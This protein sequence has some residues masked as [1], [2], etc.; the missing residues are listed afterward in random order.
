MCEKQSPGGDVRFFP[1]EFGALAC[2]PRLTRRCRSLKGITKPMS[3]ALRICIH[4][5]HTYKTDAPAA[6]A[7]AYGVRLPAPKR[8]D[9]GCANF[10]LCFVLAPPAP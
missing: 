9:S 6:D 3:S 1:E 8:V 2:A 7:R 4:I 10:T 5:T